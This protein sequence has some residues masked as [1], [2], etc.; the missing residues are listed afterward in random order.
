MIKSRF[1]SKVKKTLRRSKTCLQRSKIRRR[2]SKS[3]RRR[4]KSRPLKN[5][6]RH[7]LK[8]GNLSRICTN[9]NYD[10]KQDCL[11]D[12]ITQE[13]INPDNYILDKKSK[14]CYNRVTLQDL[15]KR[16]IER[17]NAYPDII[18]RWPHTNIPFTQAEKLFINPE[19]RRARRTRAAREI[20]EQEERLRREENRAREEQEEQLRIRQERQRVAR[21]PPQ[22]RRLYG[23]QQDIAYRRRILEGLQN[24][25]TERARELQEDI[26]A[27][28]RALERLQRALPYMNI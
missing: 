6:R 28:E 25:N 17:R 8:F 27:R 23:P 9:N 19:S 21:L 5:S 11:I 12:D 26:A 10:K 20:Q 13:C 16:N 3:H 4:S 14:N 15:L 1:R 22:E 7:F 18:D 2:R 24:M